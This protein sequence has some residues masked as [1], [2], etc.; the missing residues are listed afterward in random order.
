MA[1]RKTKFVK[2]EFYHA[3]NR[4]CGREKIFRSKGNYAFLEQRLSEYST[5]MSV[6]LIAHSL[7]PNHYHLVL[8]Q[9]GDVPVRTLVQQTFLSYSKAFNKMY[10][11]TGT[12]F[13]GPFKC[14][15]VDSESYLLSLC[16]YVHR[17][18][19]EAGL[20]KKIEDWEFSDYLRW[21]HP[22]P[23]T[24]SPAVLLAPAFFK[25][26]RHYEEFVSRSE[27]PPWV[28]G[29]ARDIWED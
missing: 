11:R 9:D 5:R 15:H 2:G 24:S 23:G 28:T 8:R 18:P 20:V 22:A 17:N 10:K 12:L 3:Y 25:S 6:E 16:R 13:E 19:L 7:M 14:R 1:E 27:P 26:A 29:S 4:G 21:I